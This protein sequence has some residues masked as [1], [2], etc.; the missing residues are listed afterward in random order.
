MEQDEAWTL[1]ALKMRRKDVLETAV[2]NHH[3]RV[4]KVTGDGV[5]VEFAGAVNA[6]Q[7][8]LI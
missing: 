3:G 8:A 7:C 2:A 6:V 1:D 4:F 5:L